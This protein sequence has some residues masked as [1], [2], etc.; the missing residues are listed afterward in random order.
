MKKKL[1]FICEGNVIRSRIAEAIAEDYVQKRGYTGLDL[2]SSGVDVDS[3]IYSPNTEI[4]RYLVDVGLK[5]GFYNQAQREEARRLDHKEEITSD[6]LQNLYRFALMRE[7]AEERSMRNRALQRN[8]YAIPLGDDFPRQT[9]FSDGNKLRLCMGENITKKV[10]KK[11]P[12]SASNL[13]HPINGYVGSEVPVT[14]GFIYAG[15]DKYLELTA[16]MKEI[17]PKVLDKF[18]S[19]NR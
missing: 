7:I 9:Q 1:E 13:V 15:V 6:K 10:L 19:K 11:V 8:G 18:V 2:S 16:Q 4:M 12:L 3:T 17:V 14:S 5:K